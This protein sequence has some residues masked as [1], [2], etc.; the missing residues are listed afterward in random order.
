MLLMNNELK[1]K[2]IVEIYIFV[3]PKFVKTDEII[4][5]SFQSAEET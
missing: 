4:C 5:K 3:I 2:S 1:L